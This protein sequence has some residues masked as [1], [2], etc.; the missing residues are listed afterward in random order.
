MLHLIEASITTIVVLPPP[1][2]RP[3]HQFCAAGMPTA[4]RL[5]AGSKTGFFVL[6]NPARQCSTLSADPDFDCSCHFS[7]HGV[8]LLDEP[9][10]RAGKLPTGG[11]P[12]PPGL[13][14]RR[15][16]TGSRSV[17]LCCSARETG[18]LGDEAGEQMGYSGNIFAAVKRGR[19]LWHLQ[20]R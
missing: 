8:H 10:A 6:I 9:D 14:N 11:Q 2:I 5:P 16:S 3:K 13:H 1:F 18:G 19:Y 12:L 20:Q 4:K 17:G 15:G 7:S